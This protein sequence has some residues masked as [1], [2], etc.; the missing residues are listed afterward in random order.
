MAQTVV[1]ISNFTHFLASDN[2]FQIFF[3]PSKFLQSN[4]CHFYKAKFHF[5]KAKLEK[6]I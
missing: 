6:E 1:H 4:S 5:T 3:S 2:I